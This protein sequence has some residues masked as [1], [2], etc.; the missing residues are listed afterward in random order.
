MNNNL[1]A[2]H[3]SLLC[4]LKKRCFHVGVFRSGCRFPSNKTK[5]LIY[6]S[7]TERFKFRSRGRNLLLR[8]TGFS[9]GGGRTGLEKS[10]MYI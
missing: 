7:T 2:D 4:E 10:F 3:S 9:T 1:I 5:V 6:D 8:P